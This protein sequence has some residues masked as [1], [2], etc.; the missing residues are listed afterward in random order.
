MS[1]KKN[2]AKPISNDEK[3]KPQN[4]AESGADKGRAE[5][6]MNDVSRGSEDDRR[7]TSQH[8]SD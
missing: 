3:F 5:R 7:R 8:R 2:P 4:V 1:E 6:N